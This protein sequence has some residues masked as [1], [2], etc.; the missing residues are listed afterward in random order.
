LVKAEKENKE[1]EL[2]KAASK[3]AYHVTRTK[4]A[5]TREKEKSSR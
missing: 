2:I 5:L 3:A 4:S 1:Q